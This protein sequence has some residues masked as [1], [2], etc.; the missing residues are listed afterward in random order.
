[1]NDMF[2]YRGSWIVFCVKCPVLPSL[3][4]LSVNLLSFKVLCK[5]KK[6]LLHHQA[7]LLINYVLFSKQQHKLEYKT[8][9]FDVHF[10]VAV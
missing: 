3:I 6:R 1:M 2:A 5:V 4:L 8:P 7:D 10:G 9:L